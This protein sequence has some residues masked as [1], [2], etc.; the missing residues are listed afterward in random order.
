M[1]R[2]VRCP[3][4]RGG[5]G[6]VEPR[7]TRL[8]N[9]REPYAICRCE[10][11]GFLFLNPQ[12]TVDE[13][14]AMYASDPYYAKEN[15]T[16]GAGRRRFYHARM[17]RL[18]HWRPERGDMLG[19]G[20]LEGG[21]ALEVARSR[22]WQVAAVEFSPILADH[23]RSVLGID[24]TVSDAW[25]LSPFQGSRFEAIVSQSLEHV[26]DP[27]ETLAQCRDLLAPNGLLMLE[28]PNQ[29]HS[30]IDLLKLAVVRIVGDRAFRWFHRDITFEYHTLY[31][32]P[33]TLRALLAYEGFEVL[34]LRTHLRAH[35]LYLGKG[36]RRKLQGL[37]HT[38]GGLLNRGPCIEVIAARRDARGLGTKAQ[39]T[40][41]PRSTW[42]H[43][44]Q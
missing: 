16:R 22:G 32:T 7:K 20:C 27:R 26:P 44:P 9:L 17:E 35:P 29:F 34:E 8:L 37:V 4:C 6:I 13:L 18:E 30:L 15:A 25:R 39:L 3:L 28:V 14:S 21:Y 23:A 19:L 36:W 10:A 24:V 2:T 41:S 11:C 31:F 42:P 5:T 40:S 38:A 12:P 43:R 1:P 33:A